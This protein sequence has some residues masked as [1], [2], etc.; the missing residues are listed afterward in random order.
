MAVLSEQLSACLVGTIDNNGYVN[1]NNDTYVGWLWDAGT[2][3]TTVAV[4]GSN[5]QAFDQSQTWRDNI[6]SSA[7]LE[8]ELSS[9]QHLQRS[10]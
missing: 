7:W 6:T 5:S 4:G 9:Y 2:T 3:T 10:V 1:G 8:Y